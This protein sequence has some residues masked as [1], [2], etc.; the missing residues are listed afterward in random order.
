MLNVAE[1]L[2]LHGSAVNT[3]LIE[4]VGE[5]QRRYRVICFNIL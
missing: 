3:S 1:A 4:F 2:G 5:E